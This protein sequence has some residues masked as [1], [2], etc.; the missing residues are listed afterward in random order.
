MLTQVGIAGENKRAAAGLVFAESVV[1]RGSVE[2]RIHVEVLRA[3]TNVKVGAIRRQVR[4][5]LIRPQGVKALVDDV[6]A[7]R[8]PVPLGRIRVC[9]VDVGAGAVVG[10]AV[11]RRSVGLVNEPALVAH[12]VVEA[13]PCLE[14]RPHADHGF[15]AHR[16]K[17]LV[18]GR[19]IG[20]VLRIEVHLAHFGVVEPV[21]DEHVGG[22]MP[23]AVSLSHG[24]HFVLSDITL[25]ALDVSVSRLRQHGRRTG[26]Q[27]VAGVDFVRGFAGD[28]KERDAVA[29]LG[30]PAGLLVEAG[31][32]GGLG[33]VIPYKA[34]ALVCNQ[35]GDAP[36]WAGGGEVVGPAAHDMA[37]MI[38]E[39]LVVLAEAVV[40][41]VVGR[42]EAGADGVELG[43][44]G[45]AVEEN[46][47][48]AFFLIG[49]VLRPAGK[50][51]QLCSI[52]SAEDDVRAGS[53]SVEIPADVHLRL[54]WRLATAVRPV[55]GDD[56]PGGLVDIGLVSLA[57]APSGG[58]GCGHESVAG[59]CE[60]RL[61]LETQS[62]AHDVWRIGF[63]DDSFA[64][65]IEQKTLS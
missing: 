24:E 41:F 30:G 51:E 48:G 59:R 8:L 47:S 57:G 45:A 18:H 28:D 52:G 60:C 1:E 10:L 42:C 37:A 12:F 4:F 22:K 43:V 64:L 34:V 50:F 23:V 65:A 58:R 9:C 54:H 25:L 14:A 62:D 16:V 31:L 32:D 3:G 40:V 26:Q 13:G 49:H 7:D 29:Y 46:S 44:A 33:R 38:E 56:H 55:G 53:G 20:P 17:L 15:K 11:D 2:K 39:A 19:G 6:F 35:E 21:D 27:P 36:A 63:Q 61:A 5:G